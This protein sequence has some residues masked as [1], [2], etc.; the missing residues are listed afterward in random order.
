MDGYI[1]PTVKQ[2]LFKLA[3]EKAFAAKILQL[4]F[5]PVAGGF[6]HTNL[7][8]RLRIVFGQE[9]PHPVRLIEREWTSACADV[10]GLLQ[11]MRPFPR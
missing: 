8:I 6:Q 9:V 2:R 1:D 4:A 11:R 7:P 3:R 5:D 10:T